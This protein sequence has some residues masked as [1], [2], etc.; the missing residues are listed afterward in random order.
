MQRTI[1]NKNETRN[2]MRAG[3]RKPQED[4]NNIIPFLW[5]NNK[6]HFVIAVASMILDCEAIMAIG[7][8]TQVSGDEC[9]GRGLR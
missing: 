4:I 2:A 5:V 3:T 8:Y 6:M 7:R 9:R 1:S